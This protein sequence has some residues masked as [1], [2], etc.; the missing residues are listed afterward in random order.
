[1]PGVTKYNLVDDAHDLRI[2]MHNDEVFKYGVCFEAK[3]IGSLEVGRPSSRVEIVA[4]MRRI[5]YEFKLKN[6]KKKKVN[7]VVSTDHIRVILRKKRKRKGW[8]WDED[9]VVV[10]QDPISRIFYVSHDAQDLKIFSYIAREGQSS[11]FRCNVFKSKRKSQ[12]MRIVRTVGQAFDVCHQLTL[13]HKNDDGEDED[14]EEDGKVA[15][16][17]A[18]P[19]KK[20]LGLAEK[21]NL[22]ATTEE[23]IDCISSSEPEKSRRE[24]G[25]KNSLEGAESPPLLLNSPIFGGPASYHPAAEA[26]VSEEHHIQLLRKQL[27]QQ[28]QQALA[29]AAQVRVLQEQLSVEANARNDA[30][31]RVQRLLQQ[32][33]DLLQHISLLVRQIQ[34]LEIKANRR[35]TSVGSQDSLL[36]I[37]FRARPPSAPCEPLPSSSCT[38]SVTA[39]SLTPVM[40][41]SWDPALPPSSSSA[42]VGA[43]V[44]PRGVS[45]SGVRLECFRF[46][47]RGLDGQ[48]P[49]QDSGENPSDGAPDDSSPLGEQVLGA[50][51]L[52]R[53]RESGIG[54]EYESNT[55]ESDDRDSWGQAEAADSSARLLNVLDPET[56]PDCLGEEVAV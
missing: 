6:I 27:Q 46:S 12:A 50:L 30:Q 9:A 3:Y 19:A 34:E 1:M 2:P 35:L 44:G 18:V 52:L 31:V 7:I 54:S 41:G 26:S 17:E 25:F 23:S 37:T 21:N 48:E 14:E 20:R 8:S 36:E 16:S 24:E 22:D 49:G 56:L 33:T 28:E 42:S 29:A 11:V 10:T 13:Q 45:R 15:E 32:N 4:A 39:P 55:D 51:E 40:D 5:R 38:R 43:D 47:T 53:F